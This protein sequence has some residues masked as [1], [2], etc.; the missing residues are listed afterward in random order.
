MLR[1]CLLIQVREERRERGIQL[2]AS[3]LP[4]GE[5]IEQLPLAA[6]HAVL[7]ESCC[8]PFIDQAVDKLEPEAD[9]A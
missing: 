7:L 9:W 4:A 8:E 1:H 3:G 6:G 2:P 5:H